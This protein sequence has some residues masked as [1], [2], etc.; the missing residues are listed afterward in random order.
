[1]LMYYENTA[2][3]LDYIEYKIGINLSCI[4]QN[5]IVRNYYYTEYD[6]Q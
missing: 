2:M 6:L 5:Q 4:A 3:Q 1:M